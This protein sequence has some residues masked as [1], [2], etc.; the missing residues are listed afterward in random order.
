MQPDQTPT[1]SL[2]NTT[3]MAVGGTAGV[4]AEI[5]RNT[6][7]KDITSGLSKAKTIPI[8]ISAL[9]GALTAG[10]IQRRLSDPTVIHRD[11]HNFREALTDAFAN[12]HGIPRE[13]SMS[14]VTAATLGA[15]G[16]ALGGIAMRAVSKNQR[17]V[18]MIMNAGT[19][20]KR[21][22]SLA[23]RRNPADIAKASFL[24]AIRNPVSF[25]ASTA[26]G[27]AGVVALD[28]LH[29]RMVKDYHNEMLA[30]AAHRAGALPWTSTEST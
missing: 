10:A 11:P 6:N 17:L 5:L 1:T 4:L 20:A 24:D 3:A 26:Q 19:N 22:A 18:D 15:V 21:A 2:S 13:N 8:S 23:A 29:D 28:A 14:P 27:S 30:E 9:V 7:T 12:E 25:A 16:T